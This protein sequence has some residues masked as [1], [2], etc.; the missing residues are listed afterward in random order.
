MTVNVDDG[1]RWEVAMSSR[2][3]RGCQGETRK[4]K[5]PIDGFDAVSDLLTTAPDIIQQ[6]DPEDVCSFTD[7]VSV[8]AIPG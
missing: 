1:R 3:E 6:V 7:T 4:S 2:R 5:I 8:V